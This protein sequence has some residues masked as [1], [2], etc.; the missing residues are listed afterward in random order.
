M[1]NEESARQPEQTAMECLNRVLSEQGDEMDRVV[2]I[3]I[4]KN[5]DVASFYSNA[6]SE[7]EM[8]GML[9]MC[10]NLSRDVGDCEQ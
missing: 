7:A 3:T 10:L 1:E 5:G 9:W 6:R 4:P 2:I 8:F